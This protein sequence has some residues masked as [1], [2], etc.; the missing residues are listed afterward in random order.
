[1]AYRLQSYSKSREEQ[2]K[3]GFIFFSFL[4]QQKLQQ[5]DKMPTFAYHLFQMGEQQEY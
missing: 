1:M 3:L 5:Y 2:N 4:R